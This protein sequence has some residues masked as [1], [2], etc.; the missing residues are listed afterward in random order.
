MKSS[1]RRNQVTD[2]IKNL[3]K[4]EC[5][6]VDQLEEYGTIF[7][8][9]RWLIATCLSE[10]ELFDKYSPI[11]EKYADFMIVTPE[12]GA[13]FT[14]DKREKDKFRKRV[15][16][17]RDISFEQGIT[18]QIFS[19]CWVDDCSTA[20]EQKAKSM[21]QRELI[22]KAINEFPTASKRRFKKIYYDGMSPNE[23]AIAEKVDRSAIDHSIELC[24]KISIRVFD[25]SNSIKIVRINGMVKEVRI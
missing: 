3:F 23:I 18:D 25:N 21:E 13:I 20:E 17:N 2:E 4:E 15:I 22:D 19:K 9:P 24:R 8:G 10:D 12:V 7:Y 14:N 11:M 16:R 6:V 5:V 1:V